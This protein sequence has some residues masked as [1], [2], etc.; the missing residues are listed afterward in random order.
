VLEAAGFAVVVPEAWL[1]CGRPLDAYGML[2]LAKHLLHRTMDALGPQIDAGVPIV[3]LEPSCVAVFRDELLG[4]FP[5]HGRARKLAQQTY[6]LSKFLEQRAPDFDVP[7]V[8]RQAVVQAHCHHTAIKRLEAE[9]ATLKKL[10]LDYTIFD[11]G[12]GG[13][14]GSFGFEAGVRYDVSIKSGEQVLLPA[15]RSAPRD[16]LVIADGFSCR[17]Q[18]AQ[19]THRRALHLAQVLQLALHQEDRDH[20][21]AG[22]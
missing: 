3:G 19:A 22:H 6:T 21:S 7:K 12:C 15:V 14:A 11:S 5:H 9:E 8:A 18:I 4:P 17:E 13:M 2:G 1:C 16:A 10:G 20:A